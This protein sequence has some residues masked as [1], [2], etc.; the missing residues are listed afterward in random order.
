MAGNGAV[1]SLEAYPII[2]LNHYISAMNE[3]NTELRTYSKGEVG[4][5][6]YCQKEF[7][8]RNR[9]IFCSA[10]CGSKYYKRTS[11]SILNGIATATV[12]AISELLVSV[13]LMKRGFHVYR[14]LSNSSY[15]DIIAIKDGKINEIEVRTGYYYK[16]K[17]GEKVTYPNS[18]IG[19]KL[20]IV[21]T[22]CDNKVHF[23]N[24]EL[25]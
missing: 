9:K 10:G 17:T 21:I 1:R 2:A 5:C 19:C 23:P 11:T 16:T 24:G 12:G 3:I 20:L 8:G 4:I 7:M 13:E 6:P 22:H 18:N 15:A 14:A 25:E